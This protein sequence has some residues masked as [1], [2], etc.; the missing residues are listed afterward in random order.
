M[1]LFASALVLHTRSVLNHF[2][3]QSDIHQRNNILP[4]MNCLMAPSMG[5]GK[6]ASPVFQRNK[7]L[8]FS[9]ER[10]DSILEEN[11]PY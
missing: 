5:P 7:W 6:M 9:F 4:L 1:G 2:V 11:P 10:C 3:S 8:S